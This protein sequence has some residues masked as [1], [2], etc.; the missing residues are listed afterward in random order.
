MIG[1]KADQQPV[2][3][4]LTEH[5]TKIKVLDSNMMS[6]VSDLKQFSWAINKMLTSVAALEEANKDI[7]VGKRRLDCLS[8][9]QGTQA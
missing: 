8:C 3:A 4:S 5:G 2:H 6:V 9:G 1:K 7:L